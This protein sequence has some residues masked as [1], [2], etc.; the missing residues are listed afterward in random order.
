MGPRGESPPLAWAEQIKRRAHCSLSPR[1]EITNGRELLRP[2][3][4]RQSKVPLM[5][6]SVHKETA[7]SATPT[8][9][10]F[11]WLYTLY[12]LLRLLEQE[13]RIFTF[14]SI[15]PQFIVGVVFAETVIEVGIQL[16]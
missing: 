14:Y 5:S 9:L 15:L 7:S 1:S 4:N 2:L 11:L 16:A 13:W 10:L 12:A 6:H 3:D 8:F